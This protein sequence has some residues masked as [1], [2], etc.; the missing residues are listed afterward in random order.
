M[1]GTT[2]CEK[3][4]EAKQRQVC[5]LAVKELLQLGIQL[6]KA[7]LPAYTERSTQC[8]GRPL[9]QQASTE[10]EGIGKVPTVLV[11]CCSFIS[12]HLQVEG[13]FR[14]EG[15][16]VRQRDLRL[17]L[18]KGLPILDATPI[19]DVCSVLKAWLR[20]LPEPL[21]PRE[22]SKI[23]LQAT[24]RR[25]LEK[26]VKIL[27]LGCLLL[28]SSQLTAMRYLCLFLK[29]VSSHSQINRMPAPNLGACLGPS[30][31]QPMDAT[32]ELLGRINGIATLLID[33]AHEIGSYPTNWIERLEPWVEPWT[34][35]I[36]QQQQQEACSNRSRSASFG[37]RALRLVGRAVSRIASRSRSRSPRLQQSQQHASRSP[38]P[39]LFNATTCPTPTRSTASRRA[40][41]IAQ[42][43]Q[44]DCSRSNSSRSSTSPAAKRRRFLM[45]RLGSVRQVG[46]FEVLPPPPLVAFRQH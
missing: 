25:T 40:P 6:P 4:S 43:R 3:L 39:V 30:L 41:V 38:P 11:A 27:R 37:Q 35:P 36:Q 14:I 29:R 8:F 24:N 10:I 5:A 16:K 20:E 28:P 44:R 1:S 9:L 15:S 32:M 21:V 17:R 42:Q 18:D 34:E 19:H 12:D 2:Y 26:Q 7:R 45:R 23:L 46:Y 31:I 33:F 22:L 13:L